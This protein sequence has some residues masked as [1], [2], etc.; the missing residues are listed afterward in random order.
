M[1]KKELEG[2]DKERR[3]K[4]ERGI[5]ELLDHPFLPTLYATLDSPRWCCLLT[6]FCPGGD[7]HVLRERQPEKRFDEAVVRYGLSLLIALNFRIDLC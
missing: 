5:L 1:D 2:R 7:L 6:E 4:T 3:A